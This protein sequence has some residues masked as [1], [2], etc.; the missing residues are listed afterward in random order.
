[1]VK[2]IG[3]K[4]WANSNVNVYFGCSND[5][6]YCYAK[7]N[8][9]R[10][11]RIQ[12]K[13]EW[14]RMLPKEKVI[15][16]G[17]RKRNGRIMFPTSH[18]ITLESKENCEIVLN[19]LLE[20]GNAV[21]ITTKPCFEIVKDWCDRLQCFRDQ[22]QWR[23]TITSLD[24]RKSEFFEPNAPCPN[25]R[26]EALNYAYMAQYKTSVSIEPYLDE[27]LDPLIRIID[28]LCTE[29]IWIGIMRKDIQSKLIVS[30]V[31][32]VRQSQDIN[33]IEMLRK[34]GCLVH[35]L[36]TIEQVEKIVERLRYLPENIRKKIRLKDSIVNLLK[37]KNNKI[38]V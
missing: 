31:K 24:L 36:Y 15:N 11:K 25:E 35:D 26:I 20:A 29:S 6:L 21:L 17:Y 34:M 16:K 32:Q 13:D 19:K 33:E 18:D 30:F 37:L 28:Y 3:T 12:N 38:E 1:M 5:C 14:K 9:W 7:D 2:T 23:F 10:F 27:D 4:E 8:A 22:I